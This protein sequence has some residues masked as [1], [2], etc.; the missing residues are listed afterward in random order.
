MTAPDEEKFAEAIKKDVMAFEKNDYDWV[1]PAMKK[2]SEIVAYA[3]L[4]QACEQHKSQISFRWGHE[5]NLKAY[6]TEVENRRKKA[7]NGGEGSSSAAA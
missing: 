4:D 1:H 5:K 3:S 2:L 6:K 7:A